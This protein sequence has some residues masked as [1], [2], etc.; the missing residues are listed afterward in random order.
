MNQFKGKTAIVTGGA[1][2]MGEFLCRKLAAAGANVIVAD[3]AFEKAGEIARE[4]RAAGGHATASALDVTD[5]GAV[6]ALV[7]KTAQENGRLDYMFNNAGILVVGEIR[8]MTPGQ[9]DRLLEVNVMGVLHGTLAAY[10]VM[11][12]QGFGH[13]V[14]TA[15]MA[16]L[17]YQPVTAAYVMSKQAAVGLSLSLRTEAAGL[18]VKVSVVCPGYVDTSLYT[19]CQSVKA[20]VQDVLGM[21]PVRAC[22]ADKAADKILSGAIKNKA[23]IVFPL[24]AR[25]LWWAYRFFP[26]GML[27]IM[28]GMVWLFRRKAR[29]SEAHDSCIKDM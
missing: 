19:N 25:I 24:H 4:I 2:G 8:D 12:R 7:E 26:I 11:L 10:S 29:T 6:Y 18:G 17:I 3:I 15:S 1:S 28:E 22:R 27:K 16:G 21:L 5:K 23:L 14:N 13:I 9:W 20:D